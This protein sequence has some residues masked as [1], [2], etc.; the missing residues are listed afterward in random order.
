[1]FPVSLNLEFVDASTGQ[2]MDDNTDDIQAQ[3]LQTTLTE[4]ETSR[5]E[6]ADS[7][8][9]DCDE[10][11]DCCVI[12][13][14]SISDACAAL[15]CGHTHF[16]FL[17]LVSWLQEHP[18]CPLCK[19]NVYKVRY[20]NAQKG[21]AVYRVPNASKTRDNTGRDENA[22]NRTGQTHLNS[23]SRSAVATSTDTSSTPSARTPVPA[24]P[25][26]HLQ[27]ASL[28]SRARLWIRRELQ[29]FSFLSD[30]DPSSSSSSGSGHTQQPPTDSSSS[31]SSSILLLRR[32]NNA[33]F[34][35]EYIVAILKTVDLQGSAGQAEGMLADFL[36]RPHARLFLH[37]LRSWLRSPA[38]SLAAWDREAPGGG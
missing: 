34:L 11:H 33:E 10:S 27:L 36:G 30:P 9:A 1:M 14:D 13:L 31:A 38:A 8:A 21:D 6:G 24:T 22:P 35:L 2:P 28:I 25:S 32:R 3:I 29:V 5:Q 26:K 19:A 7:T 15:P 4:I 16:D 18:N 20:A 37:E 23:A 17:C 12:C